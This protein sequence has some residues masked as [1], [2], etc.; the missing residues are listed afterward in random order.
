[1]APHGPRRSIVPLAIVDLAAGTVHDCRTVFRPLARI[2]GCCTIEVGPADSNR[3]DIQSIA[4]ALA[5]LPPEGGRI[6]LLAGNH[7]A[8]I[9][10]VDIGNVHFTGCAGGTKWRPVDDTLPLVTLRSTDT[11]SFHNIIMYGENAPCIVG[12]GDPLQ[13]GVGTTNTNLTLADCK[14]WAAGGCVVVL[15]GQDTARIAD[16]PVD[17]GPLPRAAA[18][19]G[20]VTL[21]AIFVQG[22]DIAIERCRIAAFATSYTAPAER[23]LGGVQ[24]GGGSQRVMLRDCRIVDG[25]G[26][27]V[28]LGSILWV[29]LDAATYAGDPEAAIDDAIARGDYTTPPGNGSGPWWGMIG[30]SFV[31]SAEGCAGVQPTP[32]GPTGDGTLV[33]PVSEGALREIL[34]EHCRI[35]QVTE[36]FYAV[37]QR[38]R[39]PNQLLLDLLA[40]APGPAREPA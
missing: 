37:V 11:I 1:M 9:D 3:G 39:F 21:P 23:A 22:T 2:D 6:C 15:H 34:I 8:N 16:C 27:G 31:I 26:I 33:L 35:P 18:A 24:I 40:G 20:G 13:A 4:Q 38:R 5:M 19:N 32:S 17:V 12:G 29:K 7:F 10:L 25:S 36:M 14:F 30:L 28:T